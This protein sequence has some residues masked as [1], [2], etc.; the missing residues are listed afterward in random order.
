MR[1]IKFRA[2]DPVQHKMLKPSYLEFIDGNAYWVEAGK[3]DSQNDG[4]VDSPVTRPVVKVGMV[5][6]QYTGLKDEGGKEI[7]EGDIVSKISLDYESG[8]PF[9]EP[10]IGAIVYKPDYLRFVL[11]VMSLHEVGVYPKYAQYEVI[12]NVHENPELLEEGYKDD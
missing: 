5:L 4:P 9:G 6:E 12:G 8:K 3:D 11:D 2:W 7:C 1:E 10:L